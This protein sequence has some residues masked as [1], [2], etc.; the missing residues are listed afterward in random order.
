MWV[1][2][3][4]AVHKGC[5]YMPKIIKSNCILYSYPLGYYKDKIKINFSAVHL[6]EGNKKKFIN[7]L[8]KDKNFKK[9]E[10]IGDLIFTLVK[11]QKKKKKTVFTILFMIQIYSFQNQL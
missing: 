4:K 5:K 10:V 11:E 1:L 7:L 9:I 6:I 2:K 3:F 8:K